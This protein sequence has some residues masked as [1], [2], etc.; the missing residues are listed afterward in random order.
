[1][2]NKLLALTLILGGVLNLTA[3]LVAP[4]L[5]ELKNQ[6]DEKFLKTSKQSFATENFIP[7]NPNHFL[8]NNSRS[9]SSYLAQS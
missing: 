2:K 1:M 6:K 9:S 3:Q 8:R 4:E 7:E 5:S